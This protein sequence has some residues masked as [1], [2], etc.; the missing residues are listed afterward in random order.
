M[1][2]SNV[3]TFA[4][5]AELGSLTAAARQLGVSSA[6]ISKQMT[7][8][9]QDLGLQLLIRTTRKI[10]LTDIGRSYYL[11]CKRIMEEVDTASALVSQVKS[12]PSGKLKVFSGRHFAATYIVPHLKEFLQKYPQVEFNLELGERTPDLGTEAID[13]IIGLSISAVGDTIQ[14]KIGKTR[15]VLCASKR[16]LKEFGIP[17]K[18]KD[19]MKHCYI[20][21]S[22]RKPDDELFFSPNENI[23][24]TPYIRVNDTQTMLNLALDGL[25][26][27][28]LHDYVVKD[29]LESGELQ[30]L[31]PSYHSTELPLYVAYPQRKFLPSKV[32]CFIDFILEK[33]Q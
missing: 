16:Y 33:I 18:P 22:M 13:V 14:R 4:L 28:M 10:E 20:A 6:A 26:I 32:R 19:L 2:F 24:L 3:Q 23:K 27:A 30:E 5:I 7:K 29:Y 9:E 17:K 31:L 11:Q 1:D 12:T 8:L 25:G 21:H 15:Y